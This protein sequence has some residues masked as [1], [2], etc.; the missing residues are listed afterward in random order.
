M[1]MPWS[2]TVL[3]YLCASMR[4]GAGACGATHVYLAIFEA[5]LQVVVDG[6]VGDLAD[7]RE[8]RDANF[9]LLGALEDGLLGELRRWLAPGLGGLLAPCALGLDLLAEL[10]SA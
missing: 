1:S 10:V 9:L 8:I 6:L 2:V 4:R 5:L 3:L 7:Q